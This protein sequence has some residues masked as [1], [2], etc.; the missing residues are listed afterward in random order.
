MENTF[1]ISYIWVAW[2]YIL[3]KSGCRMHLLRNSFILAMRH[4]SNSLRMCR[5]WISFS[6]IIASFLFSCSGLR[7]RMASQ[8]WSCRLWIYPMRSYYLVEGA[9]ANSCR[10][11][12]Y[13]SLCSHSNSTTN[14]F[15]SL[16]SFAFR[17]SSDGN[18]D[19]LLFR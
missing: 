14:S 19:M 5:S 10:Y 13:E 15:S 6:R 7:H 17:T 18:S 3:A 11:F 4:D 1:S 12:A 9:S 2:M 8:I 16:S